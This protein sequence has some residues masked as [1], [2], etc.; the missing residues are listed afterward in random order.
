[1][2]DTQEALSR[3]LLDESEAFHDQAVAYLS[4]QLCCSLKPYSS[5]NNSLN[6][7]CS[8]SPSC[9]GASHSFGLACCTCLLSRPTSSHQ[10]CLENTASSP[11][12]RTLLQPSLHPA[13][14]LIH[15]ASPLFSPESERPKV[16]L[17]SE[18][19]AFQTRVAQGL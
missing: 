2:P 3:S 14:P 5:T 18:C 10:I 16:G 9:L 13:R 19:N 8:F 17:G 15:P 6:S 11:T 7:S 12:K 1:M 4:N